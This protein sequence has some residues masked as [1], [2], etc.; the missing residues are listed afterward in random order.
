MVRC[1]QVRTKNT[2]AET[3]FIVNPTF[4]PHSRIRINLDGII[5]TDCSRAHNYLLCCPCSEYPAFAE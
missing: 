2:E 5:N 1:A 4:L 3:E